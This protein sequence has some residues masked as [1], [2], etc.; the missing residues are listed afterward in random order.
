MRLQGL[1]DSIRQIL[2]ELGIALAPWHLPAFVLV[3][4]ALLAPWWTKTLRADRA[5]RRIARIEAATGQ[6]ERRRIAA[7]ILDELGDN[8][9]GVVSFA[10]ECLRRNLGVAAEVA[11]DRLIAL[12]ALPLDRARLARKL[13]RAR[14]DRLLELVAITKLLDEGLATAARERLARLEVHYPDDPEVRELATRAATA[15]TATS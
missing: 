8:P 12:R 3:V 5:R 9:H 1:A 14:P 15:D 4:F 11:L 6:A 7:E 2:A 10:D 13:G